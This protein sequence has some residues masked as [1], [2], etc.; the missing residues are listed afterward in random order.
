MADTETAQ[1]KE[2]LTGAEDAGGA[3]STARWKILGGVLTAA[4]LAA[5]VALVL[6]LSPWRPHG[7]VVHE[8]PPDLVCRDGCTCLSNPTR[9]YCTGALPDDNTT[10][11]SNATHA[12]TGN[13]TASSSANGSAN[14]GVAGYRAWSWSAAFVGPEDTN[15]GIC[16]NGYEDV[17]TAISKCTKEVGTLQPAKW[18]S[19]GGNGDPYGIITPDV[20]SRAASSGDT[21]IA[22]GYA[23]V[24]FDVEVAVGT[25]DA[26]VSGFTSAS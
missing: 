6:L 12:D 10:G 13:S 15:M 14:G 5:V 24:I 11:G 1:Q 8:G 26:L 22:A 19:I 23:G 3:A 25:N 4:V 18:L 7:R 17:D 9:V 2:P 20:L 21:I 16:F